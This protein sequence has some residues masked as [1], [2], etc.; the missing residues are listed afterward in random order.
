MFTIHVQFNHIISIHEKALHSS[1]TPQP[2][3]DA[4][5]PYVH[6]QRVSSSPERILQIRAFCPRR[7]MAI[8][9][10]WW[11]LK[12]RSTRFVSKFEVEHSEEEGRDYVLLEFR[13]SHAH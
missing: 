3:I 12:D 9:I 11:R 6:T 7:C 13:K 8:E 4:T 1:Q 2:L 5:T 10:Y